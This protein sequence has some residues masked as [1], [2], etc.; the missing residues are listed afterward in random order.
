MDFVN[1]ATEIEAI[2]DLLDRAEPA[3]VRVYGRRRVG[4][5]DLLRRICDRRDGIYLLVDDADRRQVLDSLAEQIASATG[6]LRVPLRSWDDLFGKLEGLDAP[7]IVLD[8]FQRLMDRDAQ[9]V[10]RLQD[11]WDRSMKD[12]GPSL[13]LCGSSVGM[14]QRLTDSKT[15]PL[16]GRLA[17]DLRLKPFRYRDVRLLYPD[18][19][20]EERIRRFATF[21]GTPHYHQ[22]SVEGS[23]EDGVR[24]AFLT[25]TAPFLEEPQSLLQLEL[26]APTRYNS[27]LYEIGQGTHRLSELEQKV[28]VQ[29]GGLGPYIQLLRDDLDLIEMEQPVL[30]KERPARY[31]FSD[32]FFSFY[33]RF[34]FSSRPKIELG[35]ADAVWTTVEEQLDAHVGY[36][37]EEVVRDALRA[38]NGTEIRGVAIDFE[39]IGRWWN[40]H[41]E[42]LDLVAYGDDAVLAGEVKW[43][44]HA[45]DAGVIDDTLRRIDLIEKVG[46]RPVRPVVVARGGLTDGAEDLARQE[47]FLVLGID[48]LTSIFES[49]RSS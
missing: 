42:E 40:H 41:G 30:G 5:T 7:F 11:H 8:E 43:S 34:I 44:K 9:A 1:R 33:Y 48:D 49:D 17:G 28:G 26:K 31:V 3:L 39:K 14:M 15:G 24:H 38:A 47:N 4:K 27:I 22:F 6:S 36:H 25:P 46:S 45:V 12:T 10:S 35:R 16:F 32:P 19:N 13:I 20:E 18:A 23:L 29:R 37:F 2:E 21:G